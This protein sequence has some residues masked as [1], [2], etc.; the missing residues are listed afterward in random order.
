M[1]IKHNDI[2]IRKK[3]KETRLTH[4]QMRATASIIQDQSLPACQLLRPSSSAPTR[5]SDMTTLVRRSSVV[6]VLWHC[7][8]L[9]T[10][11][12]HNLSKP[13]NACN[14]TARVFRKVW[15]TLFKTSPFR[16]QGY[17]VST[18]HIHSVYFKMGIRD[19][20]DSWRGAGQC[21]SRG[22]QIDQ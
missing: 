21:N 13:S 17:L 18:R 11:F 3:E 14:S 2:E 6:K 20:Y 9:L 7:W 1:N 22:G 10:W 16:L 5:R 8:E 12:G 4:G 15:S 19:G